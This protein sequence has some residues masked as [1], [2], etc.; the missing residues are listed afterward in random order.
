M[1]MSLG[2]VEEGG[3]NHGVT[4]QAQTLPLIMYPLAVPFPGSL[5]G[6]AYF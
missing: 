2:S 1:F 5:S 6:C 3:G 4:W